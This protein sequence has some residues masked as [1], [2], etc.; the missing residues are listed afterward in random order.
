MFQD[1]EKATCPE[2]D[3]ILFRFVSLKEAVKK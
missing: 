3:L 2:S 1:F